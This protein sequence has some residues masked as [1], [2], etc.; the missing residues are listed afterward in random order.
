MRLSYRL[1]RSDRRLLG[2]NWKSKRPISV[3]WRRAPVSVPLNFGVRRRVDV[4]LRLA[5]VFVAQEVVDRDPS[6]S[7]RRTSC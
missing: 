3:S 6:R 4:G 5:L 1:P 2:E 7:G